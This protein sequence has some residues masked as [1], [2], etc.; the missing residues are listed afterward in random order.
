MGKAKRK[1]DVKDSK[2][3][4]SASSHVSPFAFSMQRDARAVCLSE[5]QMKMRTCHDSS[6]SLWLPV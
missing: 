1:H 5:T 4:L 2:P 3:P 6:R